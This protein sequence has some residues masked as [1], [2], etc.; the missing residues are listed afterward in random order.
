MS[1]SK[2]TCLHFPT[3]H[4][5]PCRPLWWQACWPWRLLPCKKFKLYYEQHVHLSPFSICFTCL[6]FQGCCL[7][8]VLPSCKAV[9]PCTAGRKQFVSLLSLSVCHLTSPA[10]FSRLSASD[11]ALHAQLPDKVMLVPDINGMQSKL[12]PSAFDLLF[13]LKA[14]DPYASLHEPTMCKIPK[15]VNAAW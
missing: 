11:S 8:T 13:S 9:G 2:L 15:F 10:S 7:P 4:F 3:A 6:V 5:L 14:S 1:P 12:F